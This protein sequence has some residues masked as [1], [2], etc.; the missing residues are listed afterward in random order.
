M[1]TA[2]EEA[3]HPPVPSS[4]RRRPATP[5]PTSP[6]HLVH[7][8]P[9]YDAAA[10]YG[11][12][13]Q[14]APNSIPS[15][16]KTPHPTSH[17]GYAQGYYSQQGPG[18]AS[19]STANAVYPTGYGSGYP[20][21]PAPSLVIIPAA[22]RCM[23]RMSMQRGTEVTDTTPNN[24]NNNRCCVPRISGCVCS[25]PPCRCGAQAQ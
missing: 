24:S 21:Y 9:G 12:P 7:P 25:A 3:M 17:A 13:N 4:S 1:D 5:G 15:R 23:A 20:A 6:I 22:P 18:A 14:P 11:I 8:Y 10:G 19:S 16:S 2:V